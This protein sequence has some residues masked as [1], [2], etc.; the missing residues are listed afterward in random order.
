MLLKSLR[1]KNF[2]QYKGDQEIVF[3][4]DP[5][6]N[7]TVILGNNTFGKT[8]LLQA[9]N[10]CLYQKAALVNKDMLLNYDVAAAMDNGDYEDVEVSISIIHNSTDYEITTTQTYR[11]SGA[12]VRGDNPTTKICYL[13]DNGQTEPVKDARIRSVIQSILPED[14]SDFFFFD[15]ERVANV[16]ER[17]DLTKS[18]KGLL[19][20]SVLDNALIHLGKQESKKSVLGQLYRSVD[21]NGDDRARRALEAIQSAQ[22]NREGIRDRLSECTSEIT[23]LSERKDQLDILLRNNEETKELQRK[24][25]R[26]E[27]QINSE[28][29]A[30]ASTT[31]ALLADY[32]RSSLSYYLV[33]LIDQAEGLLRETK[34]DD[35][36]V[37]DLTRL[38]LE[39][40]LARK[41]CVCGLRFEDHPEAIEH[42]KEE[43][44]YCP[45]ES[46]GNSVRHYRDSLQANR[47]DQPAILESMK[48]RR[49]TILRAKS[50]IEYYADEIDDVST[51]IEQ[52]EDLTSFESERNTIKAQLKTLNGRRDSLIRD[53]E[54]QKSEI[55]RQQKSYDE[56]SVVSEKNRQAMRYI[57]YAE[58]IQQWLEA[59]YREKEEEVRDT[60]QERVN[61]IFEQMY[62]GSRKVVIDSK[63]H[64]DLLANVS[65]SDLQTG[66]S[67]GLNRVK[68]F[69]FIAGLVSLAKERI[70]SRAGDEE[71]DLSS[72]PYPLVM[73]APF[74]NTDEIHIAN[75]SKVLPEASEQVVMF[76]MEK[77]WRYAKP[78]LG[79]KVGASYQLEK[80]S[81]Q[82]SK[83]RRQ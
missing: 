24:K 58:E 69:A 36:G 39:E 35:K 56:V 33:P 14:L 57:A 63:Y 11:K 22:E 45:P 41:T 51:L 83:L 64:V 61:A 30:L 52:K 20:L 74:S 43:M 72:E 6:K 79:A 3:S 62:H 28:Q 34:L 82:H 16:G 8:T 21:L 31:K 71:F 29:K 9:F 23:K 2:R 53:D 37:R 75:I 70:V 60:L 59:T 25:E 40:I 68:S 27:S 49:S 66:E 26:L 15:T 17:K 46:I 19:G 10:W 32:S 1:L 5:Q 76:V 50:Q 48:D 4:T 65:N 13:K 81:E 47:G 80:L 67:E 44:K 54:R 12:L 7:V 18:V 77:D 55:E 42:I 38:T 73:D 78:V